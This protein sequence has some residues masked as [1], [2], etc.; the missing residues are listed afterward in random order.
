M[1]ITKFKLFLAL[2]IGEE[3]I[4]TLKGDLL[5]PGVWVGFPGKVQDLGSGLEF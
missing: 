3:S 4:G 2:V 5:C 1:F